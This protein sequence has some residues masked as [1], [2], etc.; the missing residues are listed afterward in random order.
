MKNY[1]ITRHAM[2]QIIKMKNYKIT[3]LQ[4]MLCPKSSKCKI[5]KLQNY[6]TCYVQNHQFIFKVPQN[7]TILLYYN[8]YI[9]L[10]IKNKKL[11]YYKIT[12]Y[13]V[14]NITTL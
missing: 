8:I 5:T 13:F 9:I 10:F 14:S 6:K 2:S 12:K 1:K 4:D 3:K 11:Q 7:I